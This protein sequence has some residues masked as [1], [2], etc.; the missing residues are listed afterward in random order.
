[1]AKVFLAFSIGYVPYSYL[2]ASVLQNNDS[3]LDDQTQQPLQPKSY[4]LNGVTTFYSR[5]LTEI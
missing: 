3:H 5:N 4:T 1:M 2:K